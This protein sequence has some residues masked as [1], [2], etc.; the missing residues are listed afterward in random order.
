MEEF[1]EIVLE[2]LKVK[3][4]WDIQWICVIIV[5]VSLMFQRKSWRRGERSRVR[6]GADY[7]WM[8]EDY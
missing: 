2:L 4:Q 8:P 6:R 7:T 1:D 5:K 3:C